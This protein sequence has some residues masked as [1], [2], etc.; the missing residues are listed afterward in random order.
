VQQRFAVGGYRI[1]TDAVN[2]TPCAAVQAQ[3]LMSPSYSETATAGSAQF[4][5]SY[6]SRDV[7]AE[8]MELGGWINKAFSLGSA[9]GLALFGR[10]A[11]AHDRN[12]MPGLNATFQGLATPVFVLNGARP[13][14]D[15]ALLTI[16]S[17]VRFAQNF[18]I[19]SKV[20]GEFAHRSTTDTGTVSLRYTW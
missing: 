17:E 8:R 18:G 12:N 10:G 15:L 11:W 4:A 5:L 6:Q 19:T 9:T 1:M 2:L 14:S 16:G 13:P 3:T 20:D 7:S